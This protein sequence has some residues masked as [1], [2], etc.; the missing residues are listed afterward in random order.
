MLSLDVYV[1]TSSG[2]IPGRGHREVARAA[3][4][5]GASAVQLRAPE[6]GD[7]E[8]LPLARDLAAHCRERGVLFLVNNRVEVAVESAADGVHVGQADHPER[9][10]ERIGPKLILGL[11]VVAPEQARE[12]EHLGASYVSATVWATQTKPEAVPLGLEGLRETC[13]LTSLPVLAIGGIN[14]SNAGEVLAAGAAGVAVVSAVGAATDP[15]AATRE[16]VGAVRA[17]REDT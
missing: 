7:G 4:E 6:L 11:S 3:V 10:R 9:V 5:G 15:A 13:R 8:L 17:Y 2:Q 16:L 12:A 1:V 14:T